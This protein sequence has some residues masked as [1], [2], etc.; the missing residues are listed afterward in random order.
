MG[1]YKWGDKSLNMGSNY[2]NPT[3]IALLIT[4]HEP[5][6]TASHLSFWL[7]LRI[8]KLLNFY[9]EELRVP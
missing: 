8:L 1:S 3:Y 2:S 5:P 6:S 4:T 7:A 9:K